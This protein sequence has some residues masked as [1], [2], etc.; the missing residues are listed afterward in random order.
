MTMLQEA[1]RKNAVSV[2]TT[3]TS[4]IQVPM[5]QNSIKKVHIELTS[6]CRLM[7]SKCD[8][9]SALKK[10]TL[11][12]HDIDIDIIKLYATKD[13]DQFILCGNLGDPIYHPRFLDIIQILKDNN[14][15]VHIHTNGSGKNQTFWNLLFKLLDKNDMLWIAMDGLEDTC[16]IY[17]VNFTSEDYHNN[18]NMMKNA[19]AC[20]VNVTWIFIAFKFNEHQIE[21]AKQIAKEIGIRF[22]LRKSSRWNKNDKDKPSKQL[23]SSIV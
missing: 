11:T 12:N 20:G 10:G 18:L 6:R 23:V 19:H 2:L 15:S 13:Y 22:C 17:R 3:Q 4:F 9:V 5:M 14:K 1:V 21:Q 16:G 7:C 8:R